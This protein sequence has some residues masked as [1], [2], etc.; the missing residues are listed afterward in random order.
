MLGLDI[1][2]ISGRAIV[3]GLEVSGNRFAGIRF[4][5]DKDATIANDAEVTIANT[6]VQGNVGRGLHFEEISRVNVFNSRVLDNGATDL[7]YSTP[8]VHIA[9]GD[10]IQIVRSQIANNVSGF[11]GGAVYVVQDVSLTIS[12]SEVTGNRTTLAGGA[13]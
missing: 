8:G 6:L 13:F 3:D 7:T 2:N 12:Q 1:F 11:V 5:Q 4:I 9:G 10:D